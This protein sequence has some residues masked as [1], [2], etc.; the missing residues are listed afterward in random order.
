MYPVWLLLNILPVILVESRQVSW[1]G[2]IVAVMAI[3]RR[4]SRSGN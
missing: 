2:S 4:Q 3:P 1:P